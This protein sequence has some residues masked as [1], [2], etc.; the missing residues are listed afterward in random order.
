MFLIRSGAI[1]GF[2]LL[3]SQLG[4]NPAELLRQCGF[5]SAQLRDPNTYVSY[6]RLADLLDRAATAC[7]EPMFGLRLASGQSVLALGEIALSIR[8]Q[9]TLGAALRYANQHIS[10]HAYG[11]HVDQVPHGDLIELQL[12]FDFTNASGL[13]QLV[14]LSAGQAFNSVARM[15][16]TESAQLKIHLPQAE[17]AGAHWHS[18]RFAGHLVFASHFAGVSFPLSWTERKPRYDEE[19]LREHFQQRIRLLES[20]YPG[21]LQ[22]QVRHLIAN[23]LPSGE[24][25]VERVAAGLNVQAR[26]L[27]KRLQAQG[28]TFRDLLQHTRMEIAQRQLQHG[29]L[30]ITDLALNLG[31]ADVAIFS[32][33]F[34]RWTGCSP[35]DWRR[36]HR[37]G[38]AD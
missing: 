15:I 3:V 9:E 10:L 37:G 32:R 27:Q 11:V 29:R 22:A 2:E 21:N 4:Q 36:E 31:Y 8:Q 35:R 24:C 6:T 17:P 23:L 26:V 5:S 12:G 34:K 1:E 7:A 25:S 28:T 13:S 38:P 33:N 14:Q 18:Q 16:D 19:L 30:S 20:L